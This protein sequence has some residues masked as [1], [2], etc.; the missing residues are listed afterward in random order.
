MKKC[1]DCKYL[2]SRLKMDGK[3]GKNHEC[4]LYPTSIEI[5]GPEDYWCGQFEFKAPEPQPYSHYHVC[6]TAYGTCKI[7]GNLNAQ[8]G[9][10]FMR[11]WLAA[12]EKGGC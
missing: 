7:P 6:H 11:G 9:D 4:R 8:E 10:I 1:I 3:G 12:K 5:Y 2:R